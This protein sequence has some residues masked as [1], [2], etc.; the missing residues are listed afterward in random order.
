MSYII[1]LT[2]GTFL[3]SVPDGQL[4]TSIA[5]LS[6]IGKSYAGFGTAFNTDLVHITENFANPTPPANPLTGQFWYDNTTQTIQ[7]YNGTFFKTI[8]SSTSSPTAPSNPSVG[9]EWFNTIT[10]QLFVW[11][12]TEWLLIGPT[13]VA[14]SGLNGIATG[15]VVQNASTYYF[16][17]FYADNRLVTLMAS[18]NLIDPGIA[19]FGNIRPGFNFSTVSTANIVFAGIYNISELTVGPADQIALTVDGNNNG[20]IATT[21]NIILSATGSELLSINSNGLIPVGNNSISLGNATNRFA[22]VFTDA[23]NIE[24]LVING[25]T[26]LTTTNQTGSGV[27]V[28]AD[29]PTFE[30]EAT[31]PLFNATNGFQIGGTA[32]LNHILVGNGSEYVDSATLPAGIVSYQEVEEAGTPLTKRPILNILSPLTAVDDPTNTS[33]DIGLSDSGV[34]AGAYTSANITVDAYGRITAA[35]SSTV[36]ALIASEIATLNSEV[37]TIDGEIS[38]LQSDV[39][40]L[41][42][43]MTTA[44]NNISTLQGDVT[45]IDGEI[46]TINNEISAIDGSIST[47]QGQMTTADNNITTLFDDISTINGEITTLQ[48]DVAALTVTAT[49]NNPGGRA[50]NTMY[51]NTSGGPMY[52][53]GYGVTSGSSVGGVN[54]YTGPGAPT[55][56]VYS[57]TCTA[58]VNNGQAGFS[59]LVPNTWYYSVTATGAVDGGVGAWIETTIT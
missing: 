47:L 36:P 41:Q 55:V 46:T 15:S 56:L 8:S 5:G 4:D 28:L 39:T 7:I 38:T 51:Q 57:N 35:T 31:S 16:L 1:N 12:G 33:T 19:G 32:P 20:V 42:G 29:S 10:Q 9:D 52:V 23:L 25:G 21:G 44:D 11:N 30:T 22:N 34:A 18:D 58:T 40:T 43:Q 59:M 17:D 26:P 2:D 48:N 14:G 54:C 27:L 49:Q 3:T 37:S 24:S 6:L 45:T 50:F 13:S 53:T